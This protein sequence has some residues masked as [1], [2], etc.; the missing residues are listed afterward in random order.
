MITPAFITT[1][2]I[3]TAFQLLNDIPIIVI[4]NFKIQ[5]AT[6]LFALF[7]INGFTTYRNLIFTTPSNPKIYYNPNQELTIGDLNGI[8]KLKL[9]NTV[10]IEGPKNNFIDISNCIVNSSFNISNTAAVDYNLTFTPITKLYVLSGITQPNAIF[11]FRCNNILNINNMSGKIT[12]TTWSLDTLAVNAYDINIW[13]Y[14]YYNNGQ[15]EFLVD[16][17]TLQ[18]VNLT[19]NG[20]WYID[21]IYLTQP[22][23]DGNYHLNIKVVGSTFDKVVWGFKV[24]ILQI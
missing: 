6:T 17:S 7:N 11:I 14:P 18:Q 2:T 13:S 1:L 19:N 24:D 3:N 10:L 16:H 5:S 4:N 20:N 21:S 12:G 23:F 8:I 15:P 22:E 9:S